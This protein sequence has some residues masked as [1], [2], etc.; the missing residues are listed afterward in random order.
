M[1]YFDHDT[2]AT[3]DELIQALRLECGGAAVDVYWCIL[4]NIYRE[5][6]D[7]VPSRYQA[8]SALALHRLGRVQNVCFE[9]ARNRVARSRRA[10]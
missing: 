7:W 9:D 6:T 8:G 4:E 1:R 2:D 5:E 10:R 3:K